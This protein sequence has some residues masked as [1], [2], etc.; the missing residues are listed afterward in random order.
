MENKR[1]LVYLAALLHDIGKL[2]QRADDSE[3]TVSARLE[4]YNRQT[5]PLISYYADSGR[6]ITVSG[7]GAVDEVGRRI[8]AALEN[9]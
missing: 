2:Y 1:D 9:L 8:L 5:A 7:D 3:A 6:L 4:V